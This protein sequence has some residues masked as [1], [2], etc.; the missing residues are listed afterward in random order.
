MVRD[1]SLLLALSG[2]DGLLMS[3]LGSLLS[4]FV[5]RSLLLGSVCELLDIGLSGSLEGRLLFAR[6][7]LSLCN[8]I[9]SSFSVSLGF[10]V[11]VFDLLLGSL[12]CCLSFGFM[13][14][15]SF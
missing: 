5:S 8:F 2:S 3:F 4:G 15:S 7:L 1:L 11:E 14:L 6:L 10:R 12:L 13:L 9:G